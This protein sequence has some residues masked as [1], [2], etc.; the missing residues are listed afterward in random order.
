[1]Q[2]ASFHVEQAV[3]TFLTDMLESDFTDVL[4]IDSDESWNAA[5]VVRL[6][7]HPEEIVGASYRMKNRWDEYVGQIVY[8]DG[9]PDGKLLA[10]GTPLLKADR[11][12]G[13]FMRIKVSALKKWAEAYPER[14]DD[15]GRQLVPFFSRVVFDGVA[16]C[17]DMAFCR[18]WQDIGGEMWLDPNINIDHWGFEQHAGDLNGYLRV[19][20]T[21]KPD[22]H[23][24]FDTV[25][26]MAARIEARKVA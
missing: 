12:A 10:D 6:L 19:K 14:I 21:P 18:K 8:K 17:N 25:R 22:I 13:G 7:L 5:D 1:M 3:N 26:E 11:V 9:H 24:A 23:A 20:H 4:L 2:A 16:H 15:G